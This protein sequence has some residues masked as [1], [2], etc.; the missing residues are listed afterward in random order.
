MMKAMRRQASSGQPWPP[1]G[2]R[3]PQ[4]PECPPLQTMAR[5]L[6]HHYRRTSACLKLATTSMDCIHKDI[7]ET[8]QW[9][10]KTLAAAA[11]G[12]RTSEQNKSVALLRCAALIAAGVVACRFESLTETTASTCSPLNCQAQ[13]L[14]RRTAHQ[15]VQ[16]GRLTWSLRTFVLML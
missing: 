12:A 3:S 2:W 14:Q 1:G 4:P 16:Q 15:L 8:G 5:S 6:F 9:R 7:R 11:L 13:C 10:A